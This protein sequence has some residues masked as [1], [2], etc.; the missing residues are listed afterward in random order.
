M[1]KNK[2]SSNAFNFSGTY[3]NLSI[4]LGNL[5]G[6]V[7]TLQTRGYQPIAQAIEALTA[8]IGES[9]EIRDGDRKD[10]LE[11]LAVVS[12]EASSKPDQRK[13]GLLKSSLGFITAALG[14]EN[15][16]IPLVHICTKS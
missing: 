5:N 4:V 10:L 14:A 11:N 12:N 15:E 1:T 9:E 3:A 6:S 7:Q 2:P 8:A 13:P 16:V